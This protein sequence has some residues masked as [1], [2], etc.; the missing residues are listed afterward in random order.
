[1]RLLSC[2]LLSTL[3]TIFLS[4]AILLKLPGPFDQKALWV[5]LAVP[6]IWLGFML[7]AYWDE[8]RWRTVAVPSGAA[9]LGIALVLTSAA[10]QV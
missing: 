8:R 2:L 3:A 9:A 6:L 1:M 7:H 4:A 5:S 10:P